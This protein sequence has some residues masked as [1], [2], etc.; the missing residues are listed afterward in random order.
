[1]NSIF[2]GWFAWKK[3]LTVGTIFLG[4]LIIII[5]LQL[6]LPPQN[7]MENSEGIL[8]RSIQLADEDILFGSS[9]EPLQ[10]ANSSF[11]ANSSAGAAQ[12][13]QL[14]K[15]GE[16]TAY[17]LA[18]APNGKSLAVGSSVGIHL[19]QTEDLSEL[20]VWQSG[21]RVRGLAFSPEGTILA[22]ALF[23]DTI[24]I[25]S[26]SNGQLLRTLRGHANWVRDVAISPRGDVLASASDDDTIRLWRI[27][28]GA[29][30]RTIQEGTQGVRCV[31]FSTD[32]VVLASGLEN[33]NIGIWR[34]ADG[35]LLQIL[36]GHTDWVRTVDFSPDGKL[37]ASGS[38]DKTA[39][40]W[41]LG[42]GQ[43]LCILEGH[44]ESVLSVAF[45]PDGTIL[46]TG[47]ADKTIGLWRVADGASIG[48]WVG[49]EGFVFDVAFS[50][51]GDLL[52]SGGEDNTVRLWK[53]S[54]QIGIQVGR[55][56]PSSS[57]EESPYTAGDCRYCHHPKSSTQSA[58]VVQAQCEVCH[59][60]GASLNWCPA[61][62]QSSQPVGLSNGVATVPPRAGVPGDLQD[63]GIEI[64]GPGN[65]EIL[66]SPKDT[67]SPVF[68]D[69]VIFTDGA[70]PSQFTIQM[71]LYSDSNEL[72]RLTT[73]PLSDGTFSFP[74][75][76]NPKGGLPVDSTNMAN[77]AIPCL[78]CHAI[79]PDVF[80]PPGLVR[81]LVQVTDP[82]GSQA[83]DQRWV[84]VEQSGQASVPVQV[85]DADTGNP[86]QGISVE[87]VSRLYGWRGR[88]FN[89]ITGPQGEAVLKVEALTEASTV[90]L[91][92]TTPSVVDG[93]LYTPQD[94]VQVML[95]PGASSASPVTLQV[96]S[97][98]GQIQGDVTI[99]G[100]GPG[101]S[102]PIWA[103]RIADG[104][105]YPSQVA[106]D[107][108]F[109]FSDLPIADYI[110]ILD[111]Q[112]LASHGWNEVT[113]EIDLTA[114]PS[115][116]VDLSLTNAEGFTIQGTVQGSENTFL[117]FAWVE[118][119]QESP[120]MQINPETSTWQ[121][122]G[123][124]PGAHSLVFAAPGF[125]SQQYQINGPQ[126]N[127]QPLEVTLSQRPDMQSIPW[128]SG[129]VLLPP[130][131]SAAIQDGEIHLQSGW[132]WGQGD[133]SITV[134]L[135][136]PGVEIV[137]GSGTFAL[138]K[139]AGKTAWFFLMQGDAT[140]SSTMRGEPIRI[141]AGQMVALLEQG[142][143]SVVP[144]EAVSF[145]ALHPPTKA[146][147]SPV[148]RPTLS[149]EIQSWLKAAWA[150]SAQ[151][152]A[153]IAYVIAIMAL[154]FVPVI[155]LIFRHRRRKIDA[156]ASK[157]DAH[158][159]GDA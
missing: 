50:P 141:S 21:A 118:I 3:G 138:E 27:S 11:N 64:T 25:R 5:A 111:P 137:I 1:M 75:G 48:R 79:T 90:Y 41:S 70:D 140:I 148:W 159:Q 37:L 106:L 7:R 109:D 94:S 14:T 77:A 35:K 61:F 45:S 112:G 130:E 9:I 16:D 120:A 121:M 31:A 158:D 58:W 135:D 2:P 107:G 42:D 139:P 102:L 78:S 86:V 115:M 43:L 129:E 22:A 65:G 117:P 51:S 134:V 15:W 99:D 93:V 144:F 101:I 68:V 66:Y 154:L 110:L 38:F 80:L 33:G 114:M 6:S 95:P 4:A 116:E 132:I 29:L 147:L 149:Q 97:Q 104:K 12:V 128:G 47:S 84:L 100:T 103:V 145:L 18:F 30:L 69:G 125:Y 76:L 82:E 142:S 72:A 39:R 81:L 123:L 108:H 55:N 127:G 89:G 73:T 49:H 8:L 52:A 124:S 36:K 23:D 156:S 85:L 151:T 24:R 10:L 32:G 87:A 20:S 67:F 92:Q 113:K 13:H 143:L 131:T 71:T 17:S 122:T 63:I 74:L 146:P 34:V 46:A 157:G 152:I 105:G 28:D 44:T 83:Q 88:S 126:E 136:S 56:Q 91:L 59:P 98:R 155:G 19:L 54:E 153:V 40:I 150:A 57:E 53:V 60:E 119:D 133:E 62:P 26:A 96:H